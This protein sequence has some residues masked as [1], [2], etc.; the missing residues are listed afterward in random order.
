MLNINERISRNREVG[1]TTVSWLAN[2]HNE[3]CVKLDKP[4]KSKCVKKLS[5]LWTKM[6][7]IRRLYVTGRTNLIVI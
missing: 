2:G 6:V 4:K 1:E 3:I 7:I 5:I